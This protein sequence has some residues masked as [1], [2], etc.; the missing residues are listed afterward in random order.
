MPKGT[1]CTNSAQG[2]PPP[3]ISS[4][5][6][7]PAG[8]LGQPGTKEGHVEVKSVP[9]RKAPSFPSSTGVSREM[10]ADRGRSAGD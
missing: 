8:S 1:L 5:S 2:L 4:L 9:R 7:L 6:P 10:L 3:T